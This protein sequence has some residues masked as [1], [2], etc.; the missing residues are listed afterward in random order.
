MHL[1]FRPPCGLLH[2]FLL[3]V[4][5]WAPCQESQ[6]GDLWS[7]WYLLLRTCIWPLPWLRSSSLL[8]WLLLLGSLCGSVL[9]NSLTSFLPSCSTALY[10]WITV[11]LLVFYSVMRFQ[12]T[13]C[14]WLYREHF[15]NRKQK[16][17]DQNS[18]VSHLHSY[19]FYLLHSLLASKINCSHY[20][21]KD[22]KVIW[23]L[24]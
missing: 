10:L 1:V 15:L 14:T 19:A 17:G 5:A 23:M 20:H 18:A 21:V 22:V 6:V 24:R 7:T 9:W 13:F 4:L 12:D 8:P 11:H 16:P 3:N 2:C